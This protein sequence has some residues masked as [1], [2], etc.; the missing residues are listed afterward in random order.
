MLKK[1]LLCLMLSMLLV[2]AAAGCSKEV[3]AKTVTLK[4]VSILGGS[5]E[6]DVYGGVLAAFSAENSSIYVRDT[7][8][9]RSEAYKLDAALEATYTGTDSPDVVYY[10]A[11]ELSGESLRKYFVPLSEIRKDYPGFASGISDKAL[12]CVRADDGEVYC[13]PCFGEFSGIAVNTKLLAEIPSDKTQL[14][15]SAKELAASGVILFANPADDCAAVIRQILLCTGG[16]QSVADALDCVSGSDVLWNGT[17]AIYDEL[18]N[19]GAF[20]PAAIT[21]ELAQYVSA[22]DL[23]DAIL[24]ADRDKKNRTDAFELFNSG[25]AAMIAFSAEDYNRITV[26]DSVELVMLPLSPVNWV[27]AAYSEGFF[28][29]RTAYNSTVRRDLAVGLVDEMASA[30]NCADYAKAAGG[31]SANTDISPLGNTLS[32]SASKRV[33]ESSV[34]YKNSVSDLD[35]TRWNEIESHIA[36]HSS[37]AVDVGQTVTL[38]TDRTVDLNEL[39]TQEMQQNTVVS[40]S[41]VPAVQPA[42]I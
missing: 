1:R 11:Q 3:E 23:H 7:T 38:L 13:I 6:M 42:G 27:T 29:T 10:Y 5:S 17:L 12:D 8:V 39:K 16:E 21:D 36:A 2:L 25:K 28:I 32:A 30:Q 15:S 34:I 37:G 26:T 24:G 9:N 14:V 22:S 35:T 41:D 18:Y 33:F 4:T 31:V 19:A 20:P 40:A